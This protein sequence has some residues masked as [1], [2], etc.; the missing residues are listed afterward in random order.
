MVFI[1]QM[2][3][4]EFPRVRRFTADNLY[5]RLL[6]EPDLLRTQVHSE[7][8]LELL[9][10]A[11]WDSDMNRIEANDLSSKFAKMS[12]INAKSRGAIDSDVHETK[13]ERAV[14]EFASY[15]SLVNSR[16]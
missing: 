16:S 9:L 1:C 7:P 2:L 6:E 13:R 8:A 5:V 12:G 11:P 3:C 4:H 10:E 14:D 15:A